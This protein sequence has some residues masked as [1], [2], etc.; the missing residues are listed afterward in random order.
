MPAKIK[1]LFVF[2][3][4]LIIVPAVYSISISPS[5][6][7]IQFEPYYKNTYKFTVGDADYIEVY[8]KG[9]LSE[10][11]TINKTLFRGAGEFTVTIA[12]PEKIENPGKN[13]I[14]IGAIEAPD[15]GGTVAAIAAIQTPIDIYV[16]Y[17]GKY[18]ESSFDAP[19]VNVDETVNFNLNVNNLG[20]DDISTVYAVVDVFGSSG[21][22]IASLSSEKIKI[23]SKSSMNFKMPFDTK[24]LKAGQYSAKATVFYD[25]DKKVH[26]KNF[27][28]GDLVVAINSYTKTIFNGTINKF[29]I[30]VESGWNNKIENVYAVIDVKRRDGSL[31]ISGLKT[32]TINLDPW[33][34]K[35]FGIYIDTKGIYS[36]EYIIVI[37]LNYR[38]K[39]TV[40]EDKLMILEQE[41]LSPKGFQFN[42]LTLVLVGIVVLLV[43]ADGIWIMMH[44]KKKGNMRKRGNK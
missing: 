3:C 42:T 27:R 44:L 35:S 2:F 13:R 1:F 7:Q 16:P 22:K 4:L 26:E 18:I 6:I 14:F 39:R 31:V 30:E 9:D 23:P 36:G 12:L 5:S 19:D 41:V 28:I 24:G 15:G 21:S 11:V 20:T 37:T 17:P 32:P 40:V 25:G 38:D 8:K 10:Y 34:K 33:E 29:E 43:I